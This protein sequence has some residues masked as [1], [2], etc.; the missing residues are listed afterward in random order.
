MKENVLY[1]RPDASEGELREAATRAQLIEFIDRLPNGWDTRVGERGVK[2]SG[3]ERQRVGI[4][5][6]I[7]KNP[8]ILVL[9]E[10]T[11]ALDSATEQ[12]VQGAL[13]EAAKGR[14]TLM[15]AHRLSTVAGADE[16]IVLDA[17]KIVERGT[18]RELLDRGGLYADLWS[19]QSRAHED[20][21]AMVAE[22][23][24]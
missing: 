1:G 23:V 2:L 9:D 10:A 12:E 11:S 17:G 19:R 14:T 18:H 20:A 21:D 6:A 22:R 16:I 7:L 3:G 24:A 13:D 4:A 15:V 8:A 5:R